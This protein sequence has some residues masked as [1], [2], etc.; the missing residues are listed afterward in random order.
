MYLTCLAEIDKHYRDVLLNS[1]RTIFRMGRYN[2]CIQTPGMDYQLV[3]FG[4]K[5]DEGPTVAS[6]F[7]GLCLPDHCSSDI[8]RYGLN[9]LIDQAKLP[10]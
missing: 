8:V 3:Q 7:I 9:K 6:F 4:M 5:G 1:G 10:F 2:Q